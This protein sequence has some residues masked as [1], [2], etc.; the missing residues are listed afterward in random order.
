MGKFITKSVKHCDA[1]TA[2]LRHGH[3][4]ANERIKLKCVQSQNHLEQT[5]FPIL[6]QALF[7]HSP[8]GGD[9]SLTLLMMSVHFLSAATVLRAELLTRQSDDV[10]L[11]SL[12]YLRT[13]NLGQ[14]TYC[15]RLKLR[16]KLLLLQLLRAQPDT[17]GGQSDRDGS[18][19]PHRKVLAAL[20]QWRDLC[21]SGRPGGGEVV[22]HFRSISLLL[23]YFNDGKLEVPGASPFKNSASK[24]F[25][26]FSFQFTAY[27]NALFI[28]LRTVGVSNQQRI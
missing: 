28:V 27:R 26:S 21:Y 9:F 20:P 10:I 7:I 17:F 5:C 11:G 22:E 2:H 15:A 4:P 12:F 16:D 23:S 18:M 14:Q 8:V 25:D 1:F 13:I 3:R 19:C 24:G 6:F